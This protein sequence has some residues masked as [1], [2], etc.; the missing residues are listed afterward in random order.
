[1][2]DESIPPLS[3]SINPSE[4]LGPQQPPS[5]SAPET[6]NRVIELASW[7]APTRRFSPKPATWYLGLFVIALVIIILLAILREFWLILVVAA[8]VFVFYALAVVQPEGVVHRILSSGI[9]IGERLYPWKDLQSFWVN[10]QGVDPMLLVETKLLFP[11]TLEL[12]IMGLDPDEM[13]EILIVYLPEQEKIAGRTGSFMD[14]AILSVANSLPYREN[15][16]AW[17]K[18]KSG[19]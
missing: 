10:Q 12:Q 4:F 15:I 7:V 6:T 8:S 9:E 2:P 16:V 13:S 19:L 1:M 17:W 3:G 18:Q 11:H 5:S 14:S